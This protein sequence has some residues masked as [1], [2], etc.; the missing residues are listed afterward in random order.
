MGSADVKKY[1][2]KKCCKKDNHGAKVLEPL[3]NQELDS[4]SS[5]EEKEI[6]N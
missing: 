5:N 1:C 6:L 4:E 2:S 3:Q